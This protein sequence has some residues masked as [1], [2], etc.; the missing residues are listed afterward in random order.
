MPTFL[1]RPK[2]TTDSQEIEIKSKHARILEASPRDLSADSIGTLAI[3]AV[4]SAFK[5]EKYAAIDRDRV[6]S[7]VAM[8]ASLDAEG[9]ERA[10]EVLDA[11]V[12]RM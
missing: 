4:A 10:E 8:K 5:D 6:V 11:L 9:L 12:E 3:G 1:P 7:A 2:L